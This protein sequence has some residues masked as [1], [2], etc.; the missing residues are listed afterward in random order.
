MDY[1]DKYLS[2]KELSEY[3]GLSVSWL[4]ARTKNTC[5]DPIPCFNPGNGKI[6]VK[7]SEFDKW[8][9][10]HRVNE[11][12]YDPELVS[13]KTIKFLKKIGISPSY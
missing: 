13:Q 9:E 4:K 8:M 3:S 1:Q 5:S 10:R 6:L 12:S 11:T 2:L 7:Q